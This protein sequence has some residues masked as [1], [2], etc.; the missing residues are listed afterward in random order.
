LATVE[1]GKNL[2]GLSSKLTARVNHGFEFQKC[3]QYFIR[4]HNK[5]PSVVAVRVNNPDRLPVGIDR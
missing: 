4:A 2:A 1:C 5:T 3:R